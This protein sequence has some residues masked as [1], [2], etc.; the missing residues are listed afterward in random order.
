[1]SGGIES[2][3]AVFRNRLNLHTI[4]S[5]GL[6]EDGGSSVP[7]K[8]STKFLEMPKLFKASV[9]AQTPCFTPVSPQS[10][11]LGSEFKRSEQQPSEIN[12]KVRT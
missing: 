11:L 5:E 1:M 3:Q 8:G 7:D 4:Y 12:E 10:V 9:S 6:L 2:E